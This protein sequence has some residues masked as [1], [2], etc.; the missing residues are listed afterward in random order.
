MVQTIYQILEDAA[1][2][3][4]VVSFEFL[5]NSVGLTKHS[6]Q[7]ERGECHRALEDAANEICDF[8]EA[9]FTCLMAKK[10]TGMPGSGFF[11]TYRLHRAEEYE[12]LV[13]DV[14]PNA[15]SEPQQK[16]LTDRERE[17]VYQ[18]YE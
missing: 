2:R 9:N 18:M 16:I 3:K 1:E 11:D 10:N 8:R 14:R 7:M 17:R 6:T 12:Q 13:G 15:L 5:Y 4:T